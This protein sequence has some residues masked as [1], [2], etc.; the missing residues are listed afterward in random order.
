MRS[1]L[2]LDGNASSWTKVNRRK[3][4]NRRRKDMYVVPR[5]VCRVYHT[6]SN[7]AVS[8]SFF[9]THP[10]FDFISCSRDSPQ[11]WRP[12]MCLSKNKHVCAWGKASSWN[13]LKNQSVVQWWF[14]LQACAIIS[15][16]KII[17]PLTRIRDSRRRIRVGRYDY[18]YDVFTS[19]VA[20]CTPCSL[21]YLSSLW[22]ISEIGA[23]NSN[24]EQTHCF[25][26]TG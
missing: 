13:I 17:A 9:P 10:F 26:L 5:V 23:R 4:A 14:R 11:R 21:F 2:A 3:Y 18:T 25:Q 7:I 8:C 15:K 20:Y 1:R 19:L 16:S 22:M 6:K 12:L 24:T